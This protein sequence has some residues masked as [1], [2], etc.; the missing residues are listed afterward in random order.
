MMELEDVGSDAQERPFRRDL[1]PSTAEESAVIQVLLGEGE[2]AFC[3]YGAIDAQQLTLRGVDLRFHGFPLG[4]EPFGDVDYL[5]AFF[6]WCL[7][8]GT[9]A[10]LF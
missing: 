2:G 9:D 10:F 1:W 7:A 6:Q 3:L 4:G 5:A 8:A